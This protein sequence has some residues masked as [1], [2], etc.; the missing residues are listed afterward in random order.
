MTDTADV[1]ATADRMWEGGS[2]GTD[3]VTTLGSGMAEV[4][5]GVA[6]VPSF[7]N[8]AAVTTDDGLV[9]VDVGSQFLSGAVHQTL[10]TWTD[11]DVHTAVYSHGH[12]DHVFG[13][14][15]WEADAEAHGRPRPRVVAHE[16]VADR[17]DRYIRTAGYNAVINRR[18][19]GVDDLEWPTE[20][21]YPDRTFRDRLDLEVGGVRAELRHDRG[22][23]DDSAWV[24]LPDRKVLC[25]GDLFIWASPNA[26]NPQKVQRYPLEWA[27]ALR[28][29][30]ELFDAP[31]GGPEVLCPATAI[32][33]WGPTGSD[34]LWARRPSSSS[35]WWPRRSSA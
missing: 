7:A 10:R 33:S 5:D 18:Q 34:W 30:L 26:G 20:Y 21:R 24:W 13:M 23:T 28:R 2:L 1:L 9:L 29:M 17:F 31:G 3:P 11:L 19:F 27:V 25:T 32:R 15:R 12:I 14:H 35:P 8:V 22:E 6:F 4:A 16:A